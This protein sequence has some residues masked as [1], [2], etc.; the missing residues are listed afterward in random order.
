[1]VEV[2]WIDGWRRS[3]WCTR[4]RGGGCVFIFKSVLWSLGRLCC[5]ARAIM[6][7]SRRGK[8]RGGEEPRRAR[9]F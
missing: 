2:G 7:G 6:E 5:T 1:M 8:M 9:G 4:G 3:A